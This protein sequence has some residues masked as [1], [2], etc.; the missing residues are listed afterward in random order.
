MEK[1]IVM[2]KTYLAIADGRK[3]IV[4]AIILDQHGNVGPGIKTSNNQ[5]KE[6]MTCWGNLREFN[7]AEHLYKTLKIIEEIKD[8]DEDEKMSFIKKFFGKQKRSFDRKLL[9][10]VFCIAHWAKK[11]KLDSF[12]ENYL[13]RI[14]RLVGQ[15][16]LEEIRLMPADPAVVAVIEDYIHRKIKN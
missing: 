8:F 3:R 14:T 5:G 7:N 4:T 9:Y 6:V 16:R 13:K 15:K 10:G 12:E 1:I 11:R 2:G